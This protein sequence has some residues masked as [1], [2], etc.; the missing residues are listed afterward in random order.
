MSRAPIGTLDW[1]SDP[2]YVRLTIARCRKAFRLST[3]DPQEATRRREELAEIVQR[4]SEAG[5]PEY[6]EALCKQAARGDQQTR[7]DVREIVDGLIVG[8]ERPVAASS[9]SPI[10]VSN[11]GITFKQVA[12]LWTSG[13]LA[14]KFRRR[15][16]DIDHTENIGRLARY[17]YPVELDGRTIAET[18]M[19]DFT[20]DHADHVLAQPNL[21]DGSVRHVAQVVSRIAKL[22]AYPLR[23]IDRSPLPQ[24]WLPPR[25][26]SKEKSYLFPDEEAA[27]QRNPRVP[28]VRRLLVG[29]CARE[30]SRKENAVTLEWSDLAFEDNGEAM[31][32]LDMTKNGRGGVWT[33]DPGTAEA[34]R[35][36]R[37]VCPSKKFVFP[38]SA[39]SQ[40]RATDDWPMYVDHL[41][42]QL[43][44]GLQ[45][46]GVTR[47]KL[48]QRGPNRI[49][50]RA[51]DLRATFVTL[52]L[53][54][55]RTE[56][57]VATRTGHGSTQMIALYRRQAKTAGELKLGWLKPLHEI[58][59][60]L[61]DI[62][63]T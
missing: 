51:H 11:G 50:L 16:K 63:S 53:A 42:D 8:R 48:F 2:P 32:S 3:S 47:E 23:A 27:F 21:P 61:R 6:A 41:A 49:R 55:G 10:K 5:K 37:P 52:A 33:L 58:I 26:G 24:G 59:P 38:S 39:L 40:H 4:L 54:T 43:R 29:F 14:K 1:T 30:G 18:P 15:V 20:V 45:Q 34:L 56:D 60:E 12:D 57:W 7:A 19:R 28:L 46:V 44:D 9:T 22:A 62:S 35:R 25:N 13:E 36:W 17:V 31:I